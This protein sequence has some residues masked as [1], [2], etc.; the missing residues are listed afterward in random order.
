MDYIAAIEGAVYPHTKW[1]TDGIAGCLV[2]F[3][4]HAVIWSTS[5]SKLRRHQAKM[6][7][8]FVL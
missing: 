4:F 5:K 8:P 2:S 6:R 1:T 3:H 7:H